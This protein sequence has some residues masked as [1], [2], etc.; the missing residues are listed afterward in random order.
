VL[1]ALHKPLRLLESKVIQ[2]FFGQAFPHP[3]C[4]LG[5]IHIGRLTPHQSEPAIF[6]P[7]HP[8]RIACT[9]FLGG[10]N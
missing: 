6:L 1:D 7:T 10:Y 2:L 3:A 9:D 5:Q 8:H 4:P